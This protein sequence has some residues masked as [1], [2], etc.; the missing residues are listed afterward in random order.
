MGYVHDSLNNADKFAQDHGYVRDPG[1][2]FLLKIVGYVHDPGGYVCS[3]SWDMST[4]PADMFVHDHK[5]SSMTAAR[6]ERWMHLRIDGAEYL[7]NTLLESSR[8]RKRY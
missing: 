4:I 2:Y 6:C 5:R 1:E 7:H 3:K 8:E